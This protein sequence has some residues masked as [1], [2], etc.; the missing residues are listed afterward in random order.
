MTNA[1]AKLVSTI[2]VRGNV[3]SFLLSWDP[4]M[5][6][7]SAVWAD[8]DFTEWPLDQDTVCKILTLRLVRGHEALI[9][10]FRQLNVRS[11]IFEKWLKK[12]IEAI[13]RIC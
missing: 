4:L 12:Y 8:N 11:R 5:Q 13:I 9:D 3:F 1:L 7:L 10:Q 2:V 6:K